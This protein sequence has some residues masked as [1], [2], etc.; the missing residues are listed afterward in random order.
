MRKKELK[1]T[2]SRLSHQAAC[3]VV[4]LL[5][6]VSLSSCNEL[7]KEKRVDC[8]AHVFI[9]AVPPIDTRSWENLDISMWEDGVRTE[10][11]VASV[12]E[13]NRGYY[14][15]V[16]K[17][18]FF[19]AALL[20]GWPAEW[21]ADGFLLV[22]E[23]EECPDAVGAYLGMEIGSDELY[24]A[25]LALT[26]LYVNVFV[27][28]EGAS[29][30]YGI[31]IYATGAV[32]GY[33][34]PGSG[35]HYGPYRAKAEELSYNERHVRIPRQMPFHDIA[36]SMNTKAEEEEEDKYAFETP[37]AALE[38]LFLEVWIEN[39]EKDEMVHYLSLPLGQI[40]SER[41]YDWST[42][43]LEDIQ[44]NIRMA[45]ESLASV[46]VTIAGW[47]VVV[48]KSGSGNGNYVI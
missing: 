7:I 44:I 43:R 45:D 39:Q 26:N 2:V 8:P 9:K 46:S 35:L 18:R 29:S 10:N 24:E 3:A 12:Y 15:P 48:Y 40:A 21:F 4:F 30:G 11:A 14:I 25:P 31:D 37:E 38:K 20:G 27:E 36:R 41:G 47:T 22:P 34:Y 1:Y 17:D 5:G 6:A 19:E 16:M 32:D 28:I 23:G 33:A 13:L 42:D